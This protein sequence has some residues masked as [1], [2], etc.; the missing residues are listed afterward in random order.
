MKKTRKVT[1]Y[2][3][4]GHALAYILINRKFKYA[5]IKPDSDSLGH[6]MPYFKPSKFTEWSI[7]RNFCDPLD[8][9]NH[10]KQDFISLAGYAAAKI[11]T[12]RYKNNIYQHTSDY[13]E[14]IERSL[15]DLPDK[16]NL[17]Y[18]RFMRLYVIDVLSLELNWLRVKAIAEALIEKETLSYNDVF[19]VNRQAIDQAMDADLKNRITQKNKI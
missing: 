18:Q 8:F 6:V 19:N 3:E 15:I 13:D 4:A 5:T 17:S 10:F 1:A 7:S 9:G 11:F 12:G 2:H 16:L 14:W